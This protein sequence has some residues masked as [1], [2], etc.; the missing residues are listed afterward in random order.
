M[1]ILSKLLR[2]D[3]HK[4][5]YWGKHY[6]PRYYHYNFD[7]STEHGFDM[8]YKSKKKLFSKK[9]YK[10]EN[11]DQLM[12]GFITIKNIRWSSRTAEMGIVF[13]PNH[14][15]K[16]YGSAGMEAIFK[17][18]FDELNMERLHLRVVKFNKRA[19]VSYLKVGFKIYKEEKE[20]FENQLIN[21]LLIKTGDDFFMI[22]EDM[23]ADY[24]LMEMTKEDYVALKCR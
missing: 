21:E 16:G 18:F 10:I 6:D 8:W 3:V 14:L 20:I 1:V 15:S 24:I 9:I 11:E 12:V 2:E 22:N 19:Q 4:M 7:L 13:D 17:E 5:V 23:Y